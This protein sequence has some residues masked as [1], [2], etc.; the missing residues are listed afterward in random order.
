MAYF[1]KI[2]KFILDILFPIS[3]LSCGQG[4]DWLCNSCYKKIQ[5][6]SFQ[7]CPYCESESADSGRICQRCKQKFLSKN[8][9]WPIDSLLVS[10]RYKEN[11]LSK[12]IHTFKYN[13]VE[14]LRVPLG[15]LA[16]EA[17]LKNNFSLPDLIIPVPLHSRRLR[18]R[19]FNQSELLA[20]YIGEN[21]TPG[22]N[23]PVASNLLVRQKYT[24][25]Q[26]KVENYQERMENMSDAFIW[27]SHV[28]TSGPANLSGKSVLLIDDICTTGATLFECGKVLKQNGAKKVF[29][30]VIARQEIKK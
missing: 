12:L 17:I 3:C 29:A 19:G 7:V 22:F 9:A 2:I 11:Q 25:P 5:L 23:I 20:K 8:N 13:F 14:D 4:E 27:A 1:S 28:P 24:P 16:T 21:L 26:M 10:A 6:V 15:K 18:W 30:A